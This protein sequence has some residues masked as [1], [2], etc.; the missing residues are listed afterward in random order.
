MEIEGEKI[1]KK[2]KR[3]PKWIFVGY[4]ICIAVIIFASVSMEKR[5]RAELPEAI[6]FTTDGA[7]GMEEGKYAYLEVQGLTDEIATYGNTDD[8]S[9]SAIDRYCVAY[10]N[11]YW[12]VVDLNL[13]TIDEL[14]D[15]KEYTYST[16]ENAQTPNLNLFIKLISFNIPITLFT[17]FIYFYLHYKHLHISSNL[18]AVS[19]SIFS[20]T[21]T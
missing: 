17:L 2:G 9:D 3:M 12:Y 1:I 8:T 14:K 13:E 11:G 20:V 5:Q 4:V 16:D 7:L 10:N 18:F 21:L 15:I 6:N 19:F